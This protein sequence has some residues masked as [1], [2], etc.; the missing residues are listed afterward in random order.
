MLKTWKSA[1]PM[2]LACSLAVWF[3]IPAWGA[4]DVSFTQID[5][6]NFPIIKGYI[7]VTDETGNVLKEL[8]ASDF[9]VTEQSNLEQTPT[10]QDPVDIELIAENQAAIAVG[11]VIDRSTSMKEQI[12]DA[13]QAAKG[14][15]SLLKDEDKGAVTSF[16][17]SVVSAQAFTHQ[18]DLLVNAVD[19]ISV[20]GSTALFD[21]LYAALQ[22]CGKTSGIKAVVAFTDGEENA[23]DHSLAEVLELA[24]NVN[25]PV[26]MIGL[27]TQV[28][29]EELRNISNQT[30]GMYKYAPKASDL[31]EIYNDIGQLTRQQYLVTYTTHN[32]KYD[33]TTRTV[34]VSVTAEASTDQDS[35][36]Y[37]VPPSPSAPKISAV[38]LWS[39]E[40]LIPWGTSI[41]AGEP[42]HITAEI[43]D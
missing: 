41:Y 17:S 34:V 13:K 4:I 15:I 9:T 39:N 36:T 30:G 37:F 26:Y 32:P 2:A 10:V 35:R 3:A 20:R 27:G 6:V 14:F 28:N 21:A 40:T 43:S 7:L 29:T 16:G 8:D 42:V 1:M 24:K 11:L 38:Q 31:L 25:V 5:P 12:A 18:Q 19:S 23:S 33:G 22:E